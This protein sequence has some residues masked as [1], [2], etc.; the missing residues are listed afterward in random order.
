VEEL[1]KCYALIFAGNRLLLFDDLERGLGWAPPFCFVP[2]YQTDEESLEQA[3]QM[4]IEMP[5]KIEH[6]ICPPYEYNG[7]SA[8]A[9]LC[10]LG[11]GAVSLFEQ[12]ERKYVDKIE[13][14]KLYLQG[15]HCPLGRISRIIW[16]GF[17]L[18]ENAEDHLN[19][20]ATEHLPIRRIYMCKGNCHLIQETTQGQK[21]WPRLDPYSP[22]GF[23]Q[24]T[25]PCP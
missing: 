18:L 12:K 9:F 6:Q 14:R 5:V 11:D 2:K 1:I 13:V 16:D 21:R 24:Q 7:N 8:T 20:V 10:R 25:L 4:Q 15:G 19:E 23:M 3:F 22:T 17:S